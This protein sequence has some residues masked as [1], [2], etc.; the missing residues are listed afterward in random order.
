MA[1]VATLDSNRRPLE[2]F[3]GPDSGT[4][5]LFEYDPAWPERFEQERA[6]IVG[7][8][9]ERALSVDHIGSTSVPGLAAKPII[10]ICLAVGD[11]SDEDTYLPDLLRAGYVLRAR[12]P[13]WHEHRV[14]RTT[15]C[16]VIVHVF[17]LGSPEIERCLIFRDRLR[18]APGERELYE[19]TKRELARTPWP[20]RQHYA[21]AK[22]DVIEEIISRARALDLH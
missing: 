8:L 7:A 17:T 22:T 11:S 21:D 9:G 12:E 14:L 6:R 1:V 4:I 15:E 18:Q 10:D 16:D 19:A 5:V 13:D 3:G 20:T 2:V